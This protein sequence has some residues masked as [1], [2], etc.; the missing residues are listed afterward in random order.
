MTL[1]E[2]KQAAAVVL[3]GLSV[4]DALGELCAYR[5]ENVRKRV[6]LGMMAG[7]WWWTDDTAMAL[8]IV[9]CLHRHGAILEDELA[10]IF[11][12]NFMD[13][14]E[15]GYGMMAQRILNRI[16]AGEDW[17]SVS[18]QAFGGGSMGNGAAMRVGPLGAWFADDLDRV[19]AEAE[20]SSRVTHWHAEGIA[21][22]IA[23]AVAVACAWQTRGA[24]AE[25]VREIISK[26]VIDRTP[27]G[28]TY[29]VLKEAITLDPATPTGAAGLKL[30]NGSLVTAPDTVPFVIW[31]ALRSL[32]D[33]PEAIIGTIEAGG[34]C[35][36]NAAMVG[37]I[38]AARIG[39]SCI[40][41]DWREGREPLPAFA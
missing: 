35:D 5:S 28:D 4:G 36:T 31:S 9:E 11:A 26:E 33:Y 32:D 19:V 6:E 16:S 41:E 2:R 10:R 15:R 21:G 22:A 7:P 23:V 3:E 20:R 14:P 24:P 38:I 8:G 40:P 13:E 29:A 18:T 37:A 17:R 1:E 12:R 34:D 27:A 25:E 39:I 30:G